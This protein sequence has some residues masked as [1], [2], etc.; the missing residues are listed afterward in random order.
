MRRLV[1]D[2]VGLGFILIVVGFAIMNKNHLISLYK[3][4]YT[5]ISHDVTLE[6]NEYFREYDFLYLQNTLDYEPEEFQDLINIFYTVINSGTDKFTFYC[7]REYDDCVNDVKKIVD[8]ET[9]LVNINNFVH[10]YNTFKNVEI[11]CGSTGEI[12]L[13]IDKSYTEEEILAINKKVKQISEAILI[14]PLTD[15]DKIR[16]VHDYIINNSKYDEDRSDKGLETY[17]SDIAYG[18]LIEGYGVCGGYTEAMQLFLEELGIKSYRVSSDEHIWNAVYLDGYW[19]HLD[20][21]WDDPITDDGSD[22]LDDKYFMISTEKLLERDTK[23][24]T[25]NQN[26]FLELKQK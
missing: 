12:T 11:E 14:G 17:K 6:K 2:L 8:D 3:D 9:I 23:E 21:T 24:H 7:S 13:A 1:K 18:P 4:I 22:V 25:F 15:E 20:L 26:V 10:P 5:Y 16:K 19:L